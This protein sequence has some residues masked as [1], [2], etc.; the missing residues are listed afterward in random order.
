MN[1]KKD[2][3]H[4]QRLITLA[5]S[6]GPRLKP[7]KDATKTA[8]AW[9]VMWIQD[10]KLMPGPN[11]LHGADLYGAFVEWAKRKLIYP[12]P[13]I[14]AFGRVLR[15]IIPKRVKYGYKVYFINRTLEELREKAIKE[16]Q[17]D[18]KEEIYTN[19]TES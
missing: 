9:L 8:S 3:K 6:K 1:E 2:R 16:K 5:R 13:T 10:Y 19:E 18:L 7:P 4:I 12:I 17:E 14:S 11:E 15:G